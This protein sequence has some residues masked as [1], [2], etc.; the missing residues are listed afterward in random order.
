MK[1]R[2]L[3]SFLT[4]LAIP[5]FTLG[6]LVGQA[7][8]LTFDFNQIISGPTLTSTT[9]LGLITLMDNTTNTNDVD[10]NVTLIDTTQKLLAFYLNYGGSGTLASMT[11]NGAAIAPNQTAD[12]YP[13]IF[14]I[15]FPATGN[16]D[17]VSSFSGVIDLAGTDLNVSDFDIKDSTGFLSAAVHIGNVTGDFASYCESVDSLWVGSGEST[18]P[19]PVPEPGTILLLGAG[20]AGLGFWGRRRK[21]P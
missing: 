11:I 10:V 16:L 18:T 9:S 12:G 4:V 6:V 3:R 15:Q 8:A 20:L 1:D 17:N 7:A 14:S 5:L 13:G 21:M 2:T 19:S